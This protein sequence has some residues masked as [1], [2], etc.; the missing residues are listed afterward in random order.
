[1]SS[2][3][4]SG[5]KARCMRLVLSLGDTTASRIVHPPMD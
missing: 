3:D 1:M 2:D 4:W 5:R